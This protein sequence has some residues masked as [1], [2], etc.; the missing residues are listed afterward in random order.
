MVCAACRRKVDVTDRPPHNLC[1]A[2]SSTAVT[3]PNE[4]SG[5]SIV[6]LTFLL[7]QPGPP[8]DDLEGRPTT[9]TLS[10]QDRDH[11]RLQHR[12]TAGQRNSGT[13]SGALSSRT[14]AFRRALSGLPV[15]ASVELDG[16]GFPAERL[17]RDSA[18]VHRG[19][20]VRTVDNPVNH[21][22]T[23]PTRR[24]RD[25][26]VDDGRQIIPAIYRAL[27]ADFRRREV[28]RA[29][30]NPEVEPIT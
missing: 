2:P 25:E 24:E 13:S 5:G 1:C 11:H 6:T 20:V 30:R 22:G 28:I 8:S 27:H 12:R 10:K 15:G 16:V 18:A 17:W 3:G 21:D 4:L 9:L 7:G 29:S 26:R 14:A 19:P 23:R